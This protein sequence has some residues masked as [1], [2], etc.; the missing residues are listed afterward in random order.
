[1]HNDHPMLR[2]PRDLPVRAVGLALALLGPGLNG[3]STAPTAPIPDPLPEVLEWARPE[4][5]VGAAFLGLEVRENAS[6][7][8][9]S[10]SF[11]DG[12]RVSRVVAGSPAEA[13]GIEVGDVLL[14][15]GDVRTDDPAV[16]DVLLADAEPGAGPIV[17]Q[18]RRGDAVFDVPVALRGGATIALPAARLAWRAEPARSRAGWLAGRGGVV[19]V[20]QDP[21]GPFARAGFEPGAVL[22]ELNGEPIRSDVSLVRRLAARE[23]GSSVDVLARDGD[24]ERAATVRLFEPPRRVTEATLP[25]LAGY[26]A[27]ADGSA[28]SF[29][30]LDLWF[31]SLFEYRREGEERNWAFL[32]W[33]TFSTGVGELSEGGAR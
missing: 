15:W 10:L 20:T 2:T 13:A 19:L 33:I 22:L 5:E 31:I 11:E 21:D 24:E 1:M 25:V 8:L 27:A 9:E 17:L 16:L 30:L 6:D 4:V 23:P 12:V 7:S 18:V 32:R 26:R 3:C 29:Y 14:A 28:A